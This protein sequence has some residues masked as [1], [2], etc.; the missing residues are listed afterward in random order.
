MLHLSYIKPHWPYV[1]PAP[2][3]AMYTVDDVPAATRA[4]RELENA[5]PVLQGFRQAEVSRNFSLDHVRET[6][7]P[8][9]MG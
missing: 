8:T 9:Y 2:Y 4:P 1:A 6:V 5:H 7:I 3:H